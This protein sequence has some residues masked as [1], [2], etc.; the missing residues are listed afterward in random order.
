MLIRT[1]TLDDMDFFVSQCLRECWAVA[2]SWLE[3]HLAHDPDGCFLVEVDG[4]SIG[5]MTTT[6]YRQTGWMGNRIIDSAWRGKG[7]GTQLLRHGFDYLRGLGIKTIR[8]E[9]EETSIRQCHQLEFEDE[10]RSPRM[11][12]QGGPPAPGKEVAELTT[13]NFGEIA[14]LDAEVFGDDRMRFLEL[15]LKMSDG[16]WKAHRP[17]GDVCGFI[18]RL[19]MMNCLMIGPCVAEDPETASDIIRRALQKVDDKPVVASIPGTNTA[20]LELHRSLGFRFG[21]P[22]L[23]QRWGPSE[24]GA[25]KLD[26][27]FAL[28]TGAAG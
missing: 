24:I 7:V 16:A 23:R 6:C 9:S 2:P 18:M 5:M 15:M 11:L 17:T 25:S 14:A 3:T 8:V 1:M 10:L 20:G 4:H 12:Y 27:I 28:A 19:P 13:D 21:G 22:C 26:N